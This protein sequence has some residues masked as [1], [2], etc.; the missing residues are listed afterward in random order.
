VNSAS[1]K[2]A[3][4][5]RT[6]RAPRTMRPLGPPAWHKKSSGTFSR[7]IGKFRC[8]GTCQLG[9]SQQAVSRVEVYN[10]SSR[11]SVVNSGARQE[12]SYF[13]QEMAKHHSR[14]AALLIRPGSTQTQEDRLT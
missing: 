4:V 10:L 8:G 14:I 1:R 3:P 7:T 12:M 13:P 2:I 6:D 9:H 11:R 5:I